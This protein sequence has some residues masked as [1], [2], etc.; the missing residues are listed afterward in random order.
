MLW[1]PDAGKRKR[2]ALRGFVRAVRERRYFEADEHLATLKATLRY[3]GKSADEALPPPES[4]IKLMSLSTGLV[5]WAACALG[6]KVADLRMA[7]ETE[8]RARQL[9][10]PAETNVGCW[11]FRAEVV[12]GCGF[13]LQD[14]DSLNILAESRAEVYLRLVLSF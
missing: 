4:Y 7:L 11:D 6:S 5:G 12:L 13:P 3:A 8:A 1:T 14:Q 9:L 10:F 2:T